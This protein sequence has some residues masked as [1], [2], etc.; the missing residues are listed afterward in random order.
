MLM[1]TDQTFRIPARKMKTMTVSAMHATFVSRERA[2]PIQT[3]WA[4]VA[5]AVKPAAAVP[6]DRRGTGSTGGKPWRVQAPT[7]SA[8]SLK[9]CRQA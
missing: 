4:Q 2:D 7:D 8:S 9:R 5:E 3:V 6:P 1:T